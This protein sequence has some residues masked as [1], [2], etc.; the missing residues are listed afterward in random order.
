[1]ILDD[2]AA[3]LGSEMF[4]DVTSGTAKL[5]SVLII[6]YG[7]PPK[8]IMTKKASNLKIHAG[9]IA[10]PGGKQDDGDADM[11]CTAL[12]ETREE[13]NLDISRSD[14]IGQLETVR[15]LN[16]NFII[17]PFVSIMRS[18][19]TITCNQEVDSVLYIPAIPF[20]KTLR[21]DPDPEHNRIQEMY[22]F[23]FKGHLVWGASARMLKQI[24]DRLHARGLLYSDV[25]ESL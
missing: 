3:A 2:F 4:S 12:R 25:R 20:L 19:P 7:N 16:S 6:I 15:T 23:T 21:N 8:F 18:L 10:F 17:T 24:F 9:E 13:L 5:S 22:T 1:M 11:L 14:V